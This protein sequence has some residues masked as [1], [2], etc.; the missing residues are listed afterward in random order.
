MCWECAADDAYLLLVSRKLWTVTRDLLLVTRCCCLLP[1]TCQCCCCFKGARG[2]E[3]RPRNVAAVAHVGRHSEVAA[4]IS[5]L[6]DAENI[7][8]LHSLKTLLC[9]KGRGEKGAKVGDLRD[10]TLPMT[11]GLIY[12]TLLHPLPACDDWFKRPVNNSHISS[13]GGVWGGEWVGGGKA[14]YNSNC[15]HWSMRARHL[16]LE[17]C[18]TEGNSPSPL[19][20]AVV[21]PSI[22]GG[23]NE[24]KGKER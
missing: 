5:S 20:I 22:S 1:V 6:F 13:R 24:K 23:E 4:R 9:P 14:K 2:N 7:Y 16:S 11:A 15:S 3:R 17:Y 12:S 19:P 18:V 10:L 21:F 8:K